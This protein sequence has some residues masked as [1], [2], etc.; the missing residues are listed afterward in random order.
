M[1]PTEIPPYHMLSEINKVKV[2]FSILSG[3]CPATLGRKITVCN[4]KL[5]SIS[6]QRECLSKEII[7]R[8]KISETHKKSV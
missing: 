1:F 8:Y 4:Y 6:L 2:K 5:I 7:Y 3:F